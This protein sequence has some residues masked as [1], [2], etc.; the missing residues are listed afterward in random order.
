MADVCGP[1][2]AEALVLIFSELMTNT[3]R[4]AGVPDN[5]PLEILLEI[6]DGR[7]RG[8][9][10]DRGGGFAPERT[11]RSVPGA[12]GGYGLRIV[13]RLSRRWGVE[14]RGELSIVWFEL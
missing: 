1:E 12:D 13:D 11:P 10:A 7:V 4:H 14:Q 8:S 6:E 3:I 2:V 5:D 9:V